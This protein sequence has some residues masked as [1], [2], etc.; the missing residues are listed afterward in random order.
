MS[1]NLYP[2]HGNEGSRTGGIVRKEATDNQ[3]G[4]FKGLAG[5]FIQ[6]LID[7]CEMETLEAMGEA[8]RDACWIEILENQLNSRVPGRVRG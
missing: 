1:R 8:I 3:N 5:L 4:M 7:R 2:R 6:E